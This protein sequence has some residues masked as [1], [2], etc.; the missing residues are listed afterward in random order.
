MTDSAVKSPSADAIRALAEGDFSGV[1]DSFANAGLTVQLPARGILQINSQGQSHKHLSLLLS[2]GIHGDE[3]APIEMLAV[4]LAGLAQAPHQLGV[5]L[6]VVV[7]N[8]DAIAQGRR[9]LDA[10]MN[11]LFR[12]DRGDLQ[13]AAEAERTDIIMRAAAEFFATPAAKKWHLDLHTAIRPSLYPTFAVV[14]DVIAAAEKRGLIAWLGGAGIGAVILNR[15]SAGTFSAYTAAQ[16]GATSCTAELGQ[17]GVLGKNDLS[18]FSATQ[19]ALD[20]LLRTGQMQPFLPHPPDVFA[21]VQEIIKLSAAFKM[22]VD[23]SAKNFTAM[24]PGALVADDGDV[25]YRVGDATE[26]LVFPNS[27]VK[28]GQRA[29]LMLV[30]QQ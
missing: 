1:T 23:G 21:V 6:M 12:A 19:V 16:F 22:A 18:M 26:Y 20:A 9:Y 29:G 11:R 7:G 8:L 28:A 24:A 5:D 30:R 17:V 13:S 2:V 3:T 15:K 4:L 27:D 14:P 25:V 10:D